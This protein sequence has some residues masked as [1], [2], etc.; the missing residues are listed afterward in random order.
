MTD[1]EKEKFRNSFLRTDT[2]TLMSYIESSKRLIEIFEDMLGLKE[3][4][5]SKIYMTTVE[6]KELAEEV[7]HKRIGP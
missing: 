2:P 3:V 7:Y 6:L 1:W 4:E 5:E